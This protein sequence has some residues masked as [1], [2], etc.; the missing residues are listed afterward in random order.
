MNKYVK[1]KFDFWVNAGPSYSISKSTLQ[2]FGNSNGRG[3]STSGGASVY[4]PFKFKLS[5]DV[6]YTYTAPTATFGSDLRRTIVNANISKSF[7]K[8]NALK[9]M[10]SG[11]DLLNQNVGFNRNAYG[12]MITQNTYTTIQRYFMF[13]VT[14][15]FNHMGGATAAAK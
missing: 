6:D 5:G 10:V 4:L 14:W 13:T 3:F 2:M 12:N 9:L 11:N 8:A 15:D 7:F 1:D